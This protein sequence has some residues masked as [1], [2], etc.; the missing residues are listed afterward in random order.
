MD[1]KILRAGFAGSGFAARFHYDALQH[2]FS[3]KVEIAGVFSVAREEAKEFAAQRGN[4]RIFD[5]LEEMIDA[6]DLIHVC[7]PPAIHEQIVLAALA[8][9]KDVIVEKPL[10]GYFGDGSED[11]NGDNFPRETGLQKSMESIRRMLDAE[12]QSRGRIMYAENWIYAPPV[13]KE[14]EIIE[15]T[16]AQILWINGEQSHSGSHSLAYGQ[17]KFSG[18]GSLIGKGCHPLSAAIYF[19]H[20]EGRV[21]F[22]APIRPKTVSARTHAITRMENF[23]DKGFLK[24]HYKDIEDFAIIHVVFEDGTI[25]DVIANELSLG[26]TNNWIR[27]N[28][29]NHRTLCNMSHNNTMESF[30]PNENVF[31]NVYVVEKI[32]TKGGWSQIAPD[33]GWF[34]GYQ[35]ELD[36]F[37]RASS[38]GGPIESD[39]KLAADTI[40]TIYASYVSAERGGTEVDIP[41][42]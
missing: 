36:A 39:S 17:W 13:Q 18:G 2:V 8:K 30:A 21:R 32:E 26:G 16:K 1:K 23:D 29:N 40:T 7:V 20:V 5:S 9:D 37:Y 38:T 19:K 14:R 3:A 4:M 42:I 11:F 27:V 12:K 31:E 10:T 33:E 25:A 34:L 28:A 22:G 24:T 41:I 15:K 6:S 35:H